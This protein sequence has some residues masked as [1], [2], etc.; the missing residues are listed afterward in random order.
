MARWFF[1]VGGAAGTIAKTMSAYD[2]TV[3]DAIYGLCERYVSRQ[4]LTAMLDREFA[5]LIERLAERRGSTTRFFVFANTVAARSYSSR[6]DMQAEGWLGLRFMTEPLGES[7]D[8]ILHTCLLDVENLHQQEAL[9]ILGVNLVYAGLHWQQDL[10]AFLDS[11]LENLAA[12]R[13]EVDMLHLTGPAFKGVDNRLVAVQLV[14]RGLA[15]A[16][17]FLANGELVPPGELLYKKS[18]MVERGS[19]RPV[20]NATLHMLECALSR[21]GEEPK[22]QPET[23]TVLVEMTL[24]N[25]LDGDH[26]NHRD[27]IDRVDFLGA[28]GKNVL[29]SNFLPHHQLAAFLFRH[30]KKMTPLVMGVP[31]LREIFDEK[32]YKGLEKA[33]LKVLVGS[34]NTISRSTLIRSDQRRL[35]NSAQRTTC[36]WHLTFG[37]STPTLWITA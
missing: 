18:V 26:I 6:E 36:R 5:L 31:T 13:V 3:S 37:I 23:V 21:F 1:L 8:I 9:G 16:T 24:D 22:V 28:L 32:Y 7:S 17:M 30:T 11:L 12:G 25:L 20:T 35:V 4:R 15:K 27:F 33:L 14:Q 34:S 10:T 2:M 19:F 29:I